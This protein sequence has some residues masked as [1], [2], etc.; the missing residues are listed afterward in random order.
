MKV[1]LE[2]YINAFAGQKIFML[3][4]ESFFHEAK[5]WCR[6][7]PLSY[8]FNIL[9]RLHAMMPDTLKGYEDQGFDALLQRNGLVMEL[10]LGKIFETASSQGAAKV[11]L[12]NTH[13]DLIAAEKATLDKARAALG[14]FNAHRKALGL[15]RDNF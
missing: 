5:C 14:P 9:Y 4:T 3:D 12:G 11:G 1:V 7:T 2:D 15:D 13:P 6:E 10:G 8:H